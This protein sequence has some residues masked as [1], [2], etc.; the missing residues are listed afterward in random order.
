MNLDIIEASPV[1]MPY[2]FKVSEKDAGRREIKIETKASPKRHVIAIL[3][4]RDAFVRILPDVED[5]GSAQ[6]VGVR[7][8]E[9]LRVEAAAS[10]RAFV[11]ETSY[12][13]VVDRMSGRIA[14]G[15]PHPRS[16]ALTD[17]A[18][19]ALEAQKSTRPVSEWAKAL[20]NSVF[21]S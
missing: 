14:A 16:D 3:H 1:E 8:V 17:L 6:Y 15:L 7:D 20:T 9:V 2:W 11:T 13:S 12:V 10:P 19:K 5:M 18:Q 21:K 4:E